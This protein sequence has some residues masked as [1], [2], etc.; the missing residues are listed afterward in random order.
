MQDDTI[1]SAADEIVDLVNS[2]PASP[3]KSE[4]EEAIVKSLDLDGPLSIIHDAID[5]NIKK[6]FGEK[7]GDGTNAKS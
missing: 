3:S 4:I 1:S 2:K 7:L 6:Y 5:R